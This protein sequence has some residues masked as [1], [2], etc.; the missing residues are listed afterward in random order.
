MDNPEVANLIDRILSTA[1]GS[2][3]PLIINI[4]SSTIPKPNTS[5]VAAATD[6]EAASI[7]GIPHEGK[8]SEVRRYIEER[9]CFDAEFKRYCMEHTLRDLCHRLTNEFG[10][11]VDR[12]STR[13][14]SSHELTSR[15]PSS[16]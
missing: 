8:Y 2:G 11:F 10:W 9:K 5:S 16:A 3:S 7:L 6:A 15:M 14:N 4:F 12:K 1:A 13:L